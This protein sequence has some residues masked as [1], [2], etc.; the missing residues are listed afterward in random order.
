M[1]VFSS[2]S[3]VTRCQTDEQINVVRLDGCFVCRAVAANLTALV[4]TVENDI[5][6][7]RVGLN[8]EGAEDA[9]AGI[10]AVAGEVVNVERA[11]TARAMVA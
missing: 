4:A 9:A 3:S 1:G 7:A 11:E 10:G 5:A 2:I 8:T 6:A